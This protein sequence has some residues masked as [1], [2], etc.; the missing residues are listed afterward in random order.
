MSWHNHD[1]DEFNRRF[2][3]VRDSEFEKQQR[4]K[5]MK[6]NLADNIQKDVDKAQQSR[7]K[8]IERDIMMLDRLKEFD[9]TESDHRW[10]RHLIGLPDGRGIP[11]LCNYIQ[12]RTGSCILH[13]DN[14]YIQNMPL[15]NFN[16][17]E[18]Y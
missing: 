13:Y 6:Q 14:K 1:P 2:H 9:L 8:E 10:I 3:G 17:R 12:G 18:K 7:D 11:M 15:P 16:E 4:E 5:K